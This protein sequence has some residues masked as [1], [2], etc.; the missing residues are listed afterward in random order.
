MDLLPVFQ[1]LGVALAI[2]FLIGVER[3]WKQRREQDGERVA[4]LRTYTLIGLLGGISGRVGILFDVTVLAALAIVFG[5]AWVYFKALETKR[6]RDLSVTGLVAGLLVFALGVYAQRGEIEIAAAAGVL[7][8]G[9]LAFKDA[10]HSWL[11]LL[12]WEE[13]RSALYIFAATFIALPLLP[14][15]AIDPYGAI[16]PRE[17]WLLT[18]VIA[19]VSFVGYV[20][21]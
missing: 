21:L 14:N 5:G 10:A 4:G 8:A 20:S 2:G 1:R 12:R 19:S 17:I 18:I 6:D 13:L 15:T 11:Q 16:V 3:G 7:L 9:V